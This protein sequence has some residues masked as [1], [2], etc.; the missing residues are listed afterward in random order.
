MTGWLEG[1]K[2][3]RDSIFENNHFLFIAIIATEIKC[4][5]DGFFFSFFY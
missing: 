2:V 5:D 3:K 4:E 1:K